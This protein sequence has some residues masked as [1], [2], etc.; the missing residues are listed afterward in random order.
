MGHQIAANYGA[1]YVIGEV[2]IGAAY[3][4][5]LTVLQAPIASDA[6]DRFRLDTPDDLRGQPWL[7]ALA[8]THRP[9]VRT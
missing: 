6:G 8:S 7:Q 4:V 3:S 9:L 2:I 5:L 1:G